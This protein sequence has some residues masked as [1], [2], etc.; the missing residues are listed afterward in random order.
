MTAYIVK[1]YRSNPMLLAPFAAKYLKP[2][3]ATHKVGRACWIAGAPSWLPALVLAV[4]TAGCATEVTD[5]PVETRVSASTTDPSIFGGA[6]DD[7]SSAI[8]GVVALRVGVGTT[9]EL[10]SGALVAPNL[11]LT[12][13]HC[14]TKN[15]TTSVACDENGHSANG[16]HVSGDE[17][18]ANIAVYTGSS[19]SFAKPGVAKGRAI[20]S[21]TGPY[22]CDS[23]IALVVLD[24]PIEG[25]APLA[26]RIHATA[27]KGEVIRSI[28]YGQNDEASPIGT[29][30]RKAGVEVLAQGKAV[31]PSKTP[32]GTHEFEVGK[33]ICQGDSGGPAISEETGAV[34]GVVSRGGGCDDDFG[35]IY[36]TTAGFEQIFTDAF[37]MA[38]ATPTDEAGDSSTASINAAANASTA[39]SDGATTGAHAGGCAV[40]ARTTSSGFPGS[41]GAALAAAVALLGLRRRRAR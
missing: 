15:A 8:P 12:A 36:T 25:I 2:A 4:A 14:V 5:Q 11:V 17:E 20:V 33:S 39:A 27:R 9:F 32:L 6:K 38:G 34:I 30:F 37:A 19:P 18:P 3:T 22:L 1:R 41:A 28:G 24:S 26:V 21:P 35:H 40:T 23:D 13:R 29:R 10:C 31:S 16:P 7:D